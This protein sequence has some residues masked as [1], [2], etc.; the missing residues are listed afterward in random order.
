MVGIDVLKKFS[1]NK[2][3]AILLIVGIVAFITVMINWN[4]NKEKLALEYFY[5]QQYDKAIEE[6]IKLSEK[7]SNEGIWEAKLAEI[8]YLSKD[9][10]NLK[11]ALENAKNKKDNHGEVANTILFLSILDNNYNMVTGKENIEMEKVLSEGEVYL[12]KYPKNKRL[13]QT[14][15]FGY[16]TGDKYDKAMELIEKYPVNIN[17]SEDLALHGSMYLSIEEYD[18]AF[19]K[20]NEAY[21]IN[22]DEIKI[23]DALAQE[24]QYNKI[25]LTEKIVELN[26]GNKEEYMYKLY[27]SKIYSLENSNANKALEILKEIEPKTKEESKFIQPSIIKLM[28]LENSGNIDEAKV[29]IENLISRNGKD[30]RVAHAAAWYYYKVGDYIKSEEFAKKSLDKNE[31]YVDN[32]GFLFPEILRSTNDGKGAEPYLYMSTK[33]EPFNKNLH[34]NK[35]YYYWYT[36]KDSVRAVESLTLSRRF[37]KDKAELSYDTA[38]IYLAN[39]NFE[40]AIKILNECITDKP[41]VAKYHR[42]LSTAYVL[43]GENAKGFKELNE[44][45]NLESND[46]LTLNNYACYYLTVDGDLEKSFTNISE[47]QKKLKDDVDQYVKTTIQENFDKVLMLRESYINGQDNEVLSIPDLTMFY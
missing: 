13:I 45:Y 44:A 30:Y 12:N 23:Y 34:I 4:N 38:L 25:K 26:E 14:M 24:Y 1:L 15:I 7:E 20:L 6:Y 42:T 41:E 16:L 11:K 28:A 32:Y 31:N 40:E 47:V 21:K 22:K 37:L 29:L 27:L 39:N 8:Y 46:I 33:L 9:D 18:K 36:L 5:K 35:G 3:Y 17:S 2:K 10:E 43:T 19:E